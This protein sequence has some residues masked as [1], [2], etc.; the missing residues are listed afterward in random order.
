[1]MTIWSDVGTKAPFD[2][3]AFLAEPLRPARVASVNRSGRPILGSFWFLFAEGRFWFSSQ[4]HT[5]IV[6]ALTS[7]AEA[8]VIV[9]DFSP[10]ENIRQVRVRGRGGV[11]RHDPKRVEQI[12]QRY[13]GIELAEWP[14]L[15]RARIQDTAWALWTVTPTSGLVAAYPNFEDRELRWQHAHDSPLP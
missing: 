2:I 10:P 8:A 6:V 15:F 7:G 5:P 11:E 4:P 13:L 3:A 14:D 1:M 9:D 12:Y